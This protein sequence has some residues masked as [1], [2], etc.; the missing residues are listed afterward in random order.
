MTHW[1]FWEWVCL[2]WESRR[3]RP[4]VMVAVLSTHPQ[5][6]W[7]D[8]FYPSMHGQ[9]CGTRPCQ[10]SRWQMCRSSVILPQ[11]TMR[12]I[13]LFNLPVFW[14]PCCNTAWLR[15]RLWVSVEWLGCCL[16]FHGVILSRHCHMMLY[17]ISTV[18]PKSNAFLMFWNL[19][20]GGGGCAAW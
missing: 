10:H 20:V 3:S 4:V 15:H 19:G 18:F 5:G 17:R 7:I 1:F 8:R 6:H 16:I 2:P 13:Q 14:C 9:P 12:G 11:I